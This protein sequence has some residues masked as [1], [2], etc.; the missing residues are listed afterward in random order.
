MSF[1][2]RA[3]IEVGRFDERFRF[4]GEDEDLCM[5]M[6]RA[7]P[8]G[9]LV[10]VPTARVAHHFKS[11]LHDT[12]RRS[13]AYGRGSARMYR[14]W[15]S[16]PPTF[17]P[18]PLVVLAMLVLSARLPLFSVAALAVPHLL[19]P[20]GLRH[21]AASRSGE[22]LLDAYVQ[23]A[24]ETCGN[25]GF[26]EGLWRFRHLFPEAVQAIQAVEPRE[27]AGLVP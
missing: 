1:P 4:G 6:T 25:I 18:G 3:L 8:C 17:F 12:L 5:R 24:Q 26:L 16:A 9:R 27:G 10:F 19:H 23:L 22:S 14:K 15:P 11:S 20:Q 7:F 2:R 21:A 13:R